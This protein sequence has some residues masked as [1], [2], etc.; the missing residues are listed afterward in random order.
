MVYRSVRAILQ[1]STNELLVVEG[2]EV[3]RG[4]WTVGLEPEFGQLIEKQSA[5]TWGTESTELTMGTGGYVRFSSTR[6]YTTIAWGFPWVG[7]AMTKLDSGS[8][9]LQCGVYVQ[10]EDPAAVVV[11]IVLTTLADLKKQ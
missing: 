6:G 11:V 8:N 3:S 7:E 9:D 1:N 10:D 5:A 4:Q 2:F